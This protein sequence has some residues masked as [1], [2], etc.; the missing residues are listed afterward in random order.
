MSWGVTDGELLNVALGRLVDA[1]PL[2]LVVDVGVLDLFLD[3]G[4]LGLVLSWLL[5][6]RALDDGVLLGF[7]FAR[8][9]FVFC[10]VERC[11]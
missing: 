2:G 11:P 4:V 10:D 8:A 9:F 7:A 5:D 1:G 3:A 6:R